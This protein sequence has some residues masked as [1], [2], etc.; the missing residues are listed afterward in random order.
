MSLYK[1]DLDCSFTGVVDQAVAEKE[2]KRNL[3]SFKFN[4]NT[5]TSAVDSFYHFLVSIICERY[6][7]AQ[8]R[9]NHQ[10]VLERFRMLAW[11]AYL[12]SLD[13]NNC[14]PESQKEKRDKILT[15]LKK[16]GFKSSGIKSHEKAIDYGEKGGT[17]MDGVNDSKQETNSII[18]FENDSMLPE[19]TNS[20]FSRIIGTINRSLS[21]SS[22][23]EVD[24]FHDQPEVS[25]VSRVIGNIS[26]SMSRTSVFGSETSNGNETD[27][28]SEMKS[29]SQNE[30]MI[31]KLLGSIQR[32]LSRTSIGK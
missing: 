27:E 21:R 3:D 8:E 12:Q 24:P 7:K 2:L 31:M 29:M 25:M 26:R 6:K 4:A 13:E 1:L 16:S 9:L 28:S 17:E 18:Q 11:K 23:R 20:T 14:L 30:P 19:K 15:K 32:S 5:Q 10:K 22:L